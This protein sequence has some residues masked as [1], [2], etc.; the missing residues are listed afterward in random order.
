MKSNSLAV[1]LPRPCEDPND[2]R[3]LGRRRY[4]CNTTARLVTLGVDSIAGTWRSRPRLR[5]SDD[6]PPVRPASRGLGHATR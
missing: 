1:P 5:L 2:Y 3:C 4:A 6:A